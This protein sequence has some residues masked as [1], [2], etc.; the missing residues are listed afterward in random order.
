MKKLVAESLNEY[1]EP[2]VPK[3]VSTGTDKYGGDDESTPKPTPPKFPK[4]DTDYANH[5]H[6]PVAK[7]DEGDFDSHGFNKYKAP[8]PTLL[9]GPKEYVPRTGSYPEQVLNF[10][11]INPGRKY[12]MYEL[13]KNIDNYAQASV[14]HGVEYLVEKGIIKMV[15]MENPKSGRMAKMYFMPY[16]GSNDLIA[17]D[18]KD[19][20]FANDDRKFHRG[21]GKKD[22]GFLRL[23]EASVFNKP[24]A[25][26]K[27]KPHG[28]KTYA[29]LKALDETG[30]MPRME[31]IKFL[32]DFSHGK[33]AFDK[34]GEKGGSDGHPLRGYWS[35]ALVQDSPIGSYI[36]KNEP[37]KM[38]K[39]RSF[40]A[41]INR[42]E[43]RLV[44]SYPRKGNW[45][46]SP[47]GVKHLA[48]L[49]KKFGNI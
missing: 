35:T 7:D 46:L 20:D 16:K 30:G 13:Y 6:Y 34:A 17:G 2:R 41:M 25:N 47:E 31:M 8:E 42:H 37:K 1:Y 14:Q 26:G 29:L 5:A 24:Y 38:Y 44:Q 10:F 39:D 45:V 48:K 18:P 15:R 27:G 33:G 21:N 49:E 36:M 40:G 12:S 19:S 23:K 32:Y 22:G 28:Y 43:N 4:P 9:K 3:Y 11:K